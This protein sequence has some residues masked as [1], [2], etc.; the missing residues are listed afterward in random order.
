MGHFLGRNLQRHARKDT[1]M[2]A[3]CK[4]CKKDQKY[5]MIGEADVTADLIRGCD[6][7]IEYNISDIHEIWPQC[8][9]CSICGAPVKDKGGNIIVDLEEIEEWL[10]GNKESHVVST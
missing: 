4:Y 3:Y 6:D 10:E 2:I 7:G 1:K 9:Q 8:F 5:E